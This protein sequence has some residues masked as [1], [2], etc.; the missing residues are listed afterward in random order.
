MGH[1]GSFDEDMVRA[2]LGERVKSDIL[3]PALADCKN[4]SKP[5]MT[6][7]TKIIEILQLNYNFIFF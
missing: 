6:Q 3:E 4:E 7:I 1:D 5:I 2:L